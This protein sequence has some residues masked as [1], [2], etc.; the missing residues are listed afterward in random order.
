MPESKVYEDTE[1]R[2]VGHFQTKEKGPGGTKTP[3]L[4]SLGLPASGVVR[5]WISVV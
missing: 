3:D 5:K 2:E 1:R 4:L